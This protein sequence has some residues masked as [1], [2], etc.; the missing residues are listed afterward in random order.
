[1]GLRVW[2]EIFHSGDERYIVDKGGPERQQSLSLHPALRASLLHE[3]ENVYYF[4]VLEAMA[5]S[6]GVEPCGGVR[7]V[8][9]KHNPAISSR[10]RPPSP[11]P[12]T[13]CTCTFGKEE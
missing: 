1:M 5:L 6:F 13:S 12:T 7:P 3:P 2:T 4:L 10:H 9:M 11:S 8:F